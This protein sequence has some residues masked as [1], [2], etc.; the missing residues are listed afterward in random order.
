M[1]RIAGLVLVCHSV[2]IF[3]QKLAQNLLVDIIINN[4]HTKVEIYTVRVLQKGGTEVPL[5]LQ[6]R[7]VHFRDL[8]MKIVLIIV[9]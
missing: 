2:R 9:L 7:H 5:T 3:R 6:P 4:C 8:S 1:V